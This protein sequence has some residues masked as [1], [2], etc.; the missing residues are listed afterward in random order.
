MEYFITRLD[1]D[2]QTQVPVR[3]VVYG[4]PERDGEEPPVIEE[5]NY[6]DMQTIRKA[7]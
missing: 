6:I 7:R 3:L 5:Y 4:W 2:D 1:M